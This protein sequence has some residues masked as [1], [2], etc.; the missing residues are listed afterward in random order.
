ML[1]PKDLMAKDVKYIQPDDFL[2]SA[3]EKMSTFDIGAMP[4][5]NNGEVVGMLTDRDIVT[6]A[7][8]D[9]SNPET[10]YV[11]DA[12]T[13]EPIT[14]YEDQ[15]LDEVTKLMKENQ[16]RRLVVLN[17]DNQLTGIFSLGDLATAAIDN[18]LSGDVLEA[19]SKSATKI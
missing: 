13:A 17:R 1:T 2:K 12:M 4:V 8:A 3:A 15:E 14:C 11:K 18:R 19:I 9:G 16:I 7:I 5:V 6:R 10:T